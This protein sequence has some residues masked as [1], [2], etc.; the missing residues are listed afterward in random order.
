MLYCEDC[1]VKKEWPK[2]KSL[3]TIRR[4]CEVC[5]RPQ[6]CHD[7]PVSQLPLA[8]APVGRYEY[9]MT[10]LTGDPQPVTIQIRGGGRVV[11]ELKDCSEKEAQVMVMMLNHRFPTEEAL[12][13]ANAS[14]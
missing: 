12:E 14:S 8:K 6:D 4:K 7:V 1:R 10:R 3:P 2:S 11:A 13:E 9:T 5:G